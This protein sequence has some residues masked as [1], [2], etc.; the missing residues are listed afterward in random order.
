MSRVFPRLMKR[1]ASRVS[2]VSSSHLVI[3]V[4]CFSLCI[5]LSLF[6]CH[7][8]CLTCCLVSSNDESCNALCIHFSFSLMSQVHHRSRLRRHQP[9]H[10]HHNHHLLIQIQQYGRAKRPPRNHQAYQAYQGRPRRLS[11]CL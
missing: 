11:I 8:S 7:N 9:H 6:S 5:H 4:S 1:F 10:H 2:S 3:C